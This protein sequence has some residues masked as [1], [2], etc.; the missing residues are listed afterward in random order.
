MTK[1]DDEIIEINKHEARV[2][3][4]W[5]DCCANNHFIRGSYKDIEEVY[6]KIAEF[7]NHRNKWRW[8]EKETK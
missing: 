6:K 1:T 4:F 5:L 8:K 2:I 3:C 7:G